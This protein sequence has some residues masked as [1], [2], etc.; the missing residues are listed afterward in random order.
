MHTIKEKSV[1][2]EIS[3]NLSHRERIFR[4]STEVEAVDLDFTL[5]CSLVA[6]MKNDGTA[7]RLYSTFRELIHC[8]LKIKSS[9]LPTEFRSVE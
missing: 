6:R 7:E 4:G 8:S 5:L 3:R 1:L 9:F 2:I